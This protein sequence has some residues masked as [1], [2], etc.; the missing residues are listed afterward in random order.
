[1]TG[2]RGAVTEAMKKKSS[3]LPK[4][5]RRLTK[6]EAKARGVSY[7]AKR[8]VSADVKKVTARTPL[9]T[10]RQAAERKLRTSKEK[11]SAY[12]HSK[13][14]YGQDVYRNVKP[15]EHRRLGN[16]AHGK[17]AQILATGPKLKKSR[18]EGSS[19]NENGRVVTPSPGFNGDELRGLLDQLYQP[20]GFLGY[21]DK[22]PP[23]QVDVM[24]YQEIAF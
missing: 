3:R 8:Q 5:F 2:C 14:Q 10:N 17:K 18:W 20:R 6:A 15:A 19:F 7:S 11:Y 12:R 1:M 16:L 21:D 23:T 4:R 9:F 13:G 24:I 22:N